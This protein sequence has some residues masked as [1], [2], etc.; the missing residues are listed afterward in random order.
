MRSLFVFLEIGIVINFMVVSESFLRL[1][2]EEDF[3]WL[4]LALKMVFPVILISNRFFNFFL[5]V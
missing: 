2:L 3:V 4:Q 1:N 5:K